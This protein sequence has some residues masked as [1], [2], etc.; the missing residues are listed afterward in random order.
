M[1][2]KTFLTPKWLYLKELYEKNTNGNREFGSN[3][4]LGGELDIK[5]SEFI[6]LLGEL[7]QEFGF[8]C[9]LEGVRMDVWKERIWVLVESAG[10]LEEIAWKTDFEDGE[11]EY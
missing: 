1:N 8:D 7:T 2:K 6:D 11:E 4:E 5:S 9:V 3:F 10:L